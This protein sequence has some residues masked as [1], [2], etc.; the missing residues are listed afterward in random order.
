MLKGGKFPD[1]IDGIN[2]FLCD[3]PHEFIILEV[4]YDSNKHEMS[5]EQCFRALQY[6]SSTFSQLIT[7][8][9]V[10]S[11]FR[12]ST[13]TLGELKEREKNILVLINDKMLDF[14]HEGTHYDLYKVAVDFGC[15]LSQQYV[16]NRWHNT[17][18]A[19][20]LLHSNEKFLEEASSDY[21]HMHQFVMTPQP[22]SG[23]ADA[24][25]LLLGT[26][27]LRPVS[28]ARELYRKDLLETFL[29]D[30]ADSTAWNIVILDFVDLCPQLVKFLLGL[31]SPKC[32]HIKQA[33]ITTKDDGTVDVT[34]QVQKLTR[35]GCLFVLDFKNDLGISSD[36]GT[37]SLKARFDDEAMFEKLIDFNHNTEF[38]LCDL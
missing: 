34:E 26:K 27:S 38:L 30:N 5:S 15:H 21:W 6:L 12:L 1:I 33:V 3:N 14:A 25:Q 24:L 10:G 4:I 7:Y 13:V 31:N 17:A 28:L 35:R 11:W 37:F 18:Q 29:R 20:T 9:D 22:P 16:K 36:E 23:V 8:D 2:H 19:R 32:L